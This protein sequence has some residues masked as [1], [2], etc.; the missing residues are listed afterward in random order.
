MA[1][2]QLIPDLIGYNGNV[3]TVDPYKPRAQAF[4]VRDGAFVAVGD[5]DEIKDM[6][7]PHTRKMDFAGSTVVPGFIDAHIHVLSSGIR[8]TLMADCA[9]PSIGEIQEAMRLRAADTAAGDWVQGFKFD[10]TKTVE[11]RFLNRRDLDGVTRQHPILVAHRAG[12]VYYTNSKGLET[13]GI[14]KNSPDPPG[15][16]YGRDEATGELDGVLYETAADPIRFEL[17]SKVTP[18][19]RREGLKTI[20][21]MFAAAGLTSVHDALVTSDDV[22]IYQEAWERGELPL[23]VY[24]LVHY[25]YFGGFKASGL[26]TGFGD[27][28]LRLGGIKMVSDGAIASRTAYLSRPYE[29]SDSDCGILAM[30]P[31][32]LEEKVREVHDAGY[33]VCVHANGDATIDM[34]LTAYEKAQKANPRQD[35][36]HRLEHCTLVNPSLLNRMKALG[37]VATPFCTYVYYHGEKM[38]YYGEER[39]KWMFAQRS[40]LDYGVVATGATDYPPGPYEPLLGIQS[41]VTRTDINGNVWGANQRISVEEALKIYTL[42]SAYASFEENLKGSITAEK[43]ADFTVLGQ[44]PTAVDPHTIKDIPIEMTVVGGETIYES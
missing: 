23:R 27:D 43:L 14:D 34:V 6:A 12:H 1:S 41:C 39:V 18:D 17:L 29:G 32:E 9:L 36:R 25:R 5:N 28:R 35:T 22:A 3:I 7:G 15:G 31:D 21:N 26:K 4:A 10:D 20:C 42:H 16:R 33:Q 8:H 13:L 38:Q 37:A 40:F 24:M 2:E 11:N 19:V 44:D 30:E